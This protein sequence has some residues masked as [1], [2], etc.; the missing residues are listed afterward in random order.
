[1]QQVNNIIGVLNELKDKIDFVEEQMLE[2]LYV[3][4][5]GREYILASH[6]FRTVIAE[7]DS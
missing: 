7:D 4:P 3:A 5:K 2:K 6:I 1:M